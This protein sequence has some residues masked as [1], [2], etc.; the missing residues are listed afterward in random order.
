[1]LRLKMRGAIPPVLHMSSRQVQGQ[2][3]LYSTA[4]KERMFFK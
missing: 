2:R 3:Y 1:V 4:Q